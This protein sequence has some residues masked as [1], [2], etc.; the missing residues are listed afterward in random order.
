MGAMLSF[1]GNLVTSNWKKVD[2]SRGSAAAL[3]H[4]RH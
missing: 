2:L 4:H 3:A 1:G